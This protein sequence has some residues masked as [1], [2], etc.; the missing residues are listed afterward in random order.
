[1]GRITPLEG[2]EKRRS[3]SKQSTWYLH[4]LNW[5][6]IYQILPSVFCCTKPIPSTSVLVYG[7]RLHVMQTSH[8]TLSILNSLKSH[9]TARSSRFLPLP[10]LW[11]RQRYARGKWFFAI[12]GWRKCESYFNHPC[13][14]RGMRPPPSCTCGRSR[15][16]SAH[17][18]LAECENCWK[19]PPGTVDLFIFMH[20]PI[21]KFT[22][23]YL[24]PRLFYRKLRLCEAFHSFRA[25]QQYTRQHENS[26]L[27]G[28]SLV[29]SKS[30]TTDCPYRLRLAPYQASHLHDARPLTSWPWP[31][32]AHKQPEVAAGQTHTLLGK[33]TRIRVPLYF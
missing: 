26:Q 19:H 31:W 28:R 7:I 3:S 5:I 8:V 32:L 30:V 23:R 25:S 20:Y 12:F 22:A 27:M 24:V 14:N 17:R 18:R 13:R 1:M 4:A 16:S 6:N 15:K 9:W 29:E 21:F 10:W 2:V 11:G 33:D